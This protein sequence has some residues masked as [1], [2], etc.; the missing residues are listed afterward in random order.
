MNSLHDYLKATS[1]CDFDRAPELGNTARRLTE[2]GASSQRKMF[3]CLYQFVK[4]IRYA[5]DDWDVKASETLQ[6]QCGMCS[7][8]T[9]LLVALCRCLEIPARYKVYKIMTES[10]LW[11]WITHQD[12]ELAL[13]MG[14]PSPEQDH[15]VAEVYLNG[16][17]THDATRDSAFEEGLKRL[18]IPLERLLVC[19]A[20][21]G[22]LMVL[23]SFDDWAHRRQ[24]ARRFRKN[25]HELFSKIDKQLDKIRAL[26]LTVPE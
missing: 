5:L 11:E 13:W 4:E 26:P 14:R 19:E 25:R 23:A 21:G 10:R 9:N 1:L 18:G 15:V 7:G 20:D 16:W 12:E 2:A 22:R 3:G 8:K 17:E 6:K 24:E